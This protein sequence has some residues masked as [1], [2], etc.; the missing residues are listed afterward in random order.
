MDHSRTLSLLGRLTGIRD[1]IPHR[2][3]HALDYIQD[4]VFLRPPQPD[5]IPA[6]AHDLADLSPENVNTGAF[7]LK[8]NA[9][10]NSLILTY[11]EWLLLSLQE[12][13][14]IGKCDDGS[15]VL[16]ARS[17]AATLEEAF[18]ELERWKADRW[19]TQRSR[20]SGGDT[21]LSGDRKDSAFVVDTCTL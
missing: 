18:M 5:S 7:A 14:D 8:N 10:S 4:I 3:K 6:M 2:R 21:I 17:L 13:E 12:V 1:A 9:P 20:I 16:Q 19:E 15:V 11:E